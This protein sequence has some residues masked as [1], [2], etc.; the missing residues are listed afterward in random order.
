MDW[1]FIPCP[2]FDGCTENYCAYPGEEACFWELSEEEREEL[3][4]RPRGEEGRD[5]V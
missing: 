2:E 1:G 3:R 5:E 4:C